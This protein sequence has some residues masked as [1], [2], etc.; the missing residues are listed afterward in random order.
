ME[1][2]PGPDFPTAGY[3]Y[4]TQ[5]IRDAY[6]TGREL[7]TLRAKAVIETDERTD[8]DRIVVS[9]NPYQV[10]KAKLIEKIAELIQEKRIDGV[11]DLRD[12]SDR[13]GMRI[14]IELKKSEIPLVLLNNLYKHTPMQSTFGVI[15]LALV[16]NRP[17]VLNLKQILDAVIALIKR[18][19]SPEEARA[20]LS[21]QFR[22]TEIQANAIL[23]MKL[24]RL[25]RLEREKLIQEYEETIKKIAYLKSVLASEALVRQLIKDELLALKEEYK[26]ERRTLIVPEEAEINIEDLIAQEE[27]VV[28]ISHAGYLKRNPVS[29]YRAQRRGG[30]GKLG[31]WT[32]EEDFV[33][34]L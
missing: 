29:L 15:M 7:L 10:N 27:V 22:L 23:D 9:G 21:R 17:E 14:V 1:V 20:G 33:A 13:D 25:T 11:A 6:T 18:S 19:H 4:G 28:T 8:R 12:E 32:K 16:N 3:I 30:K 2:I 34:T 5:G 26:D 31:M 24:Q